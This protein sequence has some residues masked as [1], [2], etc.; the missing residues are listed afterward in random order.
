MTLLAD[1]NLEGHAAWFLGSIA[2][3]GWLTVL[4]IR[5]MT[6]TEVGLRPESSDRL[7]WRTAQE[8]GMVLLTGNR[9]MKGNDS[10]EQTIREEGTPAS[11]PVITVGSVERLE[12]R[13]YRERCAMRLVEIA[14]D[15]DTFLG[16]GR[17]YIP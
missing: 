1:H 7:V 5:L 16:A 3:E 9:N 17:L 14:F 8:R 10:L 11:L 6:F 13:A 12:E 4:P 2:R 15:L